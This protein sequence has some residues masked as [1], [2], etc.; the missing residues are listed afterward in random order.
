MQLVNPPL[1]ARQAES[2]AL[3]GAS[4]EA[5]ADPSGSTTAD[6]LDPATTPHRVDMQLVNP[7]LTARQAES[8]ALPGATKDAS[9]DPSGSTTADG[10]GPATRPQEAAGYRCGFLV[11]SYH[12][13]Y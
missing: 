6:G 13:D 3:P 11:H 4:K 9:A 2:P 8:P 1:T 7:P 12:G 5:S 10:L